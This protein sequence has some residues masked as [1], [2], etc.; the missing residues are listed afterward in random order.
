[1]DN[2]PPAPA[3]SPPEPWPLDEQAHLQL[4]QAMRTQGDEFAALAHMIAAQSLAAWHGGHPSYSAQPVCD[5]ATGYFMLDQHPLALRWYQLALAMEPAPQVAASAYLNL[6]AIHTRAD[7]PL[8]AQQCREQAYRLQRVFIEQTGK[9]VRRL[10]LLCEGS[11]NSNVPLDTLLGTGLNIRIKYVLDVAAE[12]EDL[13]L[14]DY[15]LV[16]NAIGDPDI[17]PALHQRLRGF[18]E[19]CQ[20]PLLNRPEDIEQTQRQHLPPRLGSIPG[21]VMPPCIR[22]DAAPASRQALWHRLQQ[23]GIA[24]PV[25]FRPWASHGGKDVARCDDLDS[26]WN[27]SCQ[28]DGSYI[29]AFHDFR[30]ADGYYRKYRMIF[31]DGEPYPYHLAISSHWMVHY[32]SADMLGQPEKQAEE[33]RFLQDPVTSLGE[34]AMQAL[35]AIGCELGLHYAGIDFSVLADGRVLV[36]EANATMLIHLERED[37]PLRDKN[38]FVTR[39]VAAF[40]RLLGRYCVPG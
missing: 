39:I 4:A 12:A 27:V 22:L 31:I 24:F 33:M 9:P 29:T 35:A 19:T 14:P 13:A 23:S 16:F 6:A 2:P 20:R 15:D 21:V 11:G 28:A 17:S 10:L 25:L 36:F 34:P 18:A 38:R 1:M 30:S 37:G 5:V 7:Q 3:S 26:L 32:F 40:E 8:L